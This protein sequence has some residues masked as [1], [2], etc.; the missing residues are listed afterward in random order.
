VKRWERTRFFVD[1]TLDFLRRN[2]DQPCFVN[3]WLDDVHSPWIPN[4]EAEKEK[5]P[6]VI[7]N[8]RRVV[9]EM[10]TQIGRLTLGL[11]ALGIDDQTLVIFTSD[12][13]PYPHLHGRTGDLRGCKFS[14]YEGGL[15]LPFIARW[16]GVVPA[17]ATDSVTVLSS[18]DMFPTLCQIAGAELPSGVAF[19]GI[20]LHDSLK[21]IRG[22]RDRPLM[23]E[24]GR[25][26]KFFG[27]P[28]LPDDR[29][30]NLAIRDGH[31]KLLVNA[32]GENV[33]LYDLSADPSEANNVAAD[34]PEIAAR[35]KNDVLKWRKSMPSPSQ[36]AT[37]K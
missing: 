5:N 12:N 33:E 16:P 8:L 32:D 37:T 29:S 25:N 34:N 2:T 13:G 24:Y 15:R 28:K 7:K 11:Q 35:L 18:V 22:P 19:D 23:W 10:D 36:A 26:A 21:G 6:N 30:P 1:K 17:G 27:Y 31:W 14:L 20:D 4:D 3:L 9:T